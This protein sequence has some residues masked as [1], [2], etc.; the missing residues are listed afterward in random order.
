MAAWLIHFVIC[1]LMG[2]GASR[3]LGAEKDHSV[4]MNAGAGLVGAWI[5]GLVMNGGLI[6]REPRLIDLIGAFGGALLVV[7]AL[8]FIRARRR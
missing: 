6:S 7:A 1:A 3:I 2:W 8:R 5:A 4:A